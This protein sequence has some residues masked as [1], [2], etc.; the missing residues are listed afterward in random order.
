MVIGLDVH[1][2]ETVGFVVDGDLNSGNEFTVKTTN[3]DLAKVAPK[4]LGHKIIIEASTSGKAVARCLI[5]HGLDVDLVQADVLTSHIR[6]AKSDKIDAR[7]L[8]RIGLM[9]GYKTCYIPRPDEEEMRALV[10][11]IRDLREEKARAKNRAKAIFQRNLMPEP[12][13]NL[14]NEHVRAKWSRARLPPAEKIALHGKLNAIAHLRNEDNNATIELCQRLTENPIAKTLLTIPGVNIYTAAAIIAYC[15]DF[16]RFPDA[17]KI[18]AYA[19]LTPRMYQSGET[20]RHGRI[21]KRGPSILRFVLV[22]AVHQINRFPGRLRK[23]H[24]RLA[25]RIGNG[26]AKVAIARTLLTAMW[27]MI[28][29]GRTYDH[30]DQELA[31]AKNWR[32]H[33]VARLASTDPGAAKQLLNTFDLKRA[34]NAWARGTSKMVPP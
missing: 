8:A 26:R 11:H 19:G 9:G 27:S 14:D 7:D 33:Q 12:G 13:G 15:G 2:K 22:E 1:K 17:K 6:S 3:G 20:M 32:I 30:V 31:A 34:R 16:T 23:K 4:L 18:A 29:Q 21:T 28:K 24:A 25:P 10:G 5:A